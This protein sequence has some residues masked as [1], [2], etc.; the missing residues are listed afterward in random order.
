MSESSEASLEITGWGVGKLAHYSQDSH[1]EV[2]L[3]RA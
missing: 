2:S 3:I 1:I